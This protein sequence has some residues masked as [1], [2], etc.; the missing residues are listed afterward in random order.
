MSTQAHVILPDDRR[1]GA[2][3]SLEIDSKARLHPVA[4]IEIM[5]S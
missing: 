5:P 1:Y 2:L 3:F 4:H